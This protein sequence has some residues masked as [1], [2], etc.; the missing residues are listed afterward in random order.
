MLPTKATYKI[1]YAFTTTVKA[2]SFSGAIE[3][4][5]LKASQYYSSS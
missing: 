1:N 5:Y 3:E 2:G 4:L